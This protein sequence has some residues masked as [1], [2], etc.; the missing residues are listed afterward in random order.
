MAW[1]AVAFPG[2]PFA[3]QRACNLFAFYRF[4]GSAIMDVCFVASLV[5]A[6]NLH[7]GRYGY[8]FECHINREQAVGE[9]ARDP[10][11]ARPTEPGAF[12]F[13]C[14]PQR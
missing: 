9:T 14:A 4:A 12:R 6:W 13:R 10:N 5:F 7:A 2:Y 1:V 8:F 3:I 11:G